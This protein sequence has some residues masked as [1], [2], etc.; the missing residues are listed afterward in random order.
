MARR[1]DT[2]FTVRTQGLG[3]LNRSLG[4]IDKELR[5]GSLREIRE[6]AK[7]VRGTARGLTPVKTGKLQGSLRYSASNRGAAITSN[8]PYA[9]V[10]E[11][12]GTISPK[13]VPITIK[14]SRMVGRAIQKDARSIEEQ[15]GDVFDRVARG[16]GFR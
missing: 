4:R 8:L 10:A 2:E 7:K 5:K 16:N 9:G 1:G 12:G 15:I 13:G 3:Q 11:Y 14:K 6:I